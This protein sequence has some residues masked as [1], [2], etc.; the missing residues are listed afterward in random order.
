MGKT[1]I[2]KFTAVT[3]FKSAHNGTLP[4][5][6]SKMKNKRLMTKRLYFTHTLKN[7]SE[8]MLYITALIV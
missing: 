8:K 6:F 2:L 1:T 4:N 3:N 7:Y 5:V